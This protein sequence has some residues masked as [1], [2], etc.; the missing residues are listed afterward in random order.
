MK[1]SV[2]MAT[3]NGSRFIE[4]QI[5]S[6]LPQLSY[7]DEL[8]IVDDCSSDQTV[9]LIQ[10]FTDSRIKLWENTKNLGA[11][12]NFE[13]SITNAEGDIIFLS[14]QDDIWMPDKVKEVTSVFTQRQEV[15]LVI[16]NLQVIDEHDN[17]VPNSKLVGDFRPGLIQNFVKSKFRGCTLAVRQPMLKYF[18]PFPEDIPMHDMWIGLVNEIYGQTLY[19]DKPLL[20]YRRHSSNVTSENHAEI[21][22]MIK[23]RYALFKNLSMLILKKMLF[24]SNNF[25]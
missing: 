11:I 2:C 12:K 4:K 17:L 8:V 20:Q 25:P 6:I 5:Q 3:Y 23:W 1:I 15:T 18:L 9:N 21:R 19:I 7:N 13:K 10:K 22:Q 24:D 14:D 16:T